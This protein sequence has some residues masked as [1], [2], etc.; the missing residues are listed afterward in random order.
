M[1][2]VTIECRDIEKSF[3]KGND[4]YQVL[5]KI[6]LTAYEKQ[7]IIIMG[8]SGSGKSTLLSI[9]AA[10]IKPD[11][12]SSLVLGTDMNAL[13]EQRR[14]AFRGKNIGFMFQDVRLIP[15]LTIQQ[16]VAIP[17][18][19]QNIPENI[20]FEKARTLLSDFGLAQDLQSYPLLLSGGEQQRVSIARACIHRPKII[21][22]DE[23]TSF[24]DAER[25]KKIME[26][27]RTIKE[28]EAATI[29]IITHD[30][31]ILSYADATYLLEDGNLRAV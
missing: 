31:R 18:L 11:R 9:M 6:N 2:T 27:L 10:L 5:K 25:G 20:A 17:L 14:T 30:S 3:V 15:T 4:Q 8:P 29:V 23:P 7:I 21:L 24:L 28:E 26:L 13:S 12:G 16:N 19:L 1:R 22:C